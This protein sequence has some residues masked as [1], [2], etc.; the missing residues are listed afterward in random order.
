MIRKKQDPVF[1]NETINNNTCRKLRQRSAAD[2]CA[3]EVDDLLHMHR[4]G[5]V[6]LITAWLLPHRTQTHA[7]AKTQIFLGEAAVPS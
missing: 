6:E 3:L 7:D 2:H 1:Q 4:H 5:A